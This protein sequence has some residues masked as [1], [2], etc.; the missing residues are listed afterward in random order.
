MRIIFK[1]TV[2]GVGFRPTVY[3]TATSLGLRG[4]VWNEGPDVIVD[5]DDGERFLEAFEPRRPPLAVIE[6]VETSEREV[7]ADTFAILRSS[8]GTGR[9]SIPTDTAICP[10]CLAELRGVGRRNSY[11][12]ISCPDCGPRFTL[13][14]GLPYDRERTAMRGFPACPNCKREF[15]D[16][17]DRRLH[18]QTVCCPLCGPRYFLLDRYGNPSIGDPIRRFAGNLEIGMTGVLKG[19]GGMHIC[20]IPENVGELR[21]QYGRRHKPFAIMIRDL[22]ALKR[23]ATADGDERRELRSA[24]RPI[25][26]LNK[27]Y[28]RITEQISPGLDNIGVMLP[29]SG[30]QHL[31]FDNLR[32]DALIMTSANPP[33][34]PMVTDNDEALRLG[35]DMYLLH[36]QPIVNR[37]DDSVMRIFDGN[38]QFLRKSRGHIPGMLDTGFDGS[39]V[40]VGAQE[41]LV[42]AAAAGGRIHFTQHIGDGGS[43]GVV[44]YLEEALR[45]NMELTGCVPQAVA[46]D[47]H[48]GY[49][50]RRLARR[51]AEEHGAEFIEVQ[52]HWAHAASLMAEKG[53]DR[54]VFLTLDGT[55]H[56]DDGQAWGGEVLCADLGG[57]RRIA[58]LEGIPLLGSERALYDLRRLR[59]AV[60][61]INGT[62]NDSFDERDAAVLMKLMDR[63]VTSTSMGRV[64]D[65]LAYSLGV[66][67]ERTYDGEPAMRLERYLAKGERVEGFETQTRGGTV[68]TAHLFTGLG[69][70]IRTEDAAYSLVHG[71]MAELVANAAEHAHAE[72][73]TQIGITGGVSY[74]GPICRMFA[75]MVAAEGLEPLFHDSVP[76][77]DGGISAGQALI[78]LNRIAGR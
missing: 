33:G 41:N 18:H 55:G 57:Y 35:A 27:R 44:D 51:L 66:C 31:L 25:V 50:N 8:P 68:L 40:A 15:F 20:C 26:L 5:V 21:E 10:E 2:Q 62:A 67:R 7:E 37:A 14:H 72:G 12:F 52:H 43:P 22:D 73:L 46:A 32:T 56:G 64:L 17:G 4:A 74:N 63:S 42:G 77:G 75:D 13:L 61:A 49:A 11:P 16:S 9:V 36:D 19:W 78:A 71:I 30:V 39:A 1:G 65:T 48:P 24:Q 45:F 34:E 69:K 38:R 47:L 29:Y 6:S 28:T 58:H 70:G 76:N 60:D 23:Y 59:F 3:R 53:I 54:G